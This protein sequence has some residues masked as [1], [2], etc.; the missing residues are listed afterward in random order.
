MAGAEPG[1]LKRPARWELYVRDTEH[2]L[3]AQWI[4]D[5]RY[6]AA[7][8]LKDY[9]ERLLVA[10]ELPLHLKTEP[11]SP[12]RQQRRR[13]AGKATVVGK[14]GAAAQVGQSG[15]SSAS[16]LSAQALPPRSDPGA[17]AHRLEHPEEQQRHEAK[18]AVETDA[19]PSISSPRSEAT[20]AEAPSKS[21]LQKH[22]SDGNPP[23]L[24]SQPVSQVPPA[25]AT[26]AEESSPSAPADWRARVRGALIQN[27]RT[28]GL[29]NDD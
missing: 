8:Y 19:A 22:T 21:A 24:E 17:P 10:G 20:E 23:P 29:D 12:R 15:P 18:A 1:A 4:A 11:S 13:A 2:P 9:M 6:Q 25:A 16:A 27:E 26:A 7:T 5:N 14:A 28:L 3:F